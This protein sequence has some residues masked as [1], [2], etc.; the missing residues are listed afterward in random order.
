MALPGGTSLTCF[1]SAAVVLAC[2]TIL[3]AT[4]WSQQPSAPTQAETANATM[5]RS[6]FSVDAREEA[7]GAAED[8]GKAARLI[9]RMHSNPQLAK[10]PNEAKGIFVVPKFGRGAV[11]V[12]GEGGVGLL[13]LKHNNRW[14][15]PAFYDLGGV[16]VGAQIGGERPPRRGKLPLAKATSHCGPTSRGCLAVL[17]SA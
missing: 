17:R 16:S 5:A 2:S 15:D 4:A 11:G 12:D 9:Q 10:L 8:V 7:R 3:S 6:T 13:L 14:S 1:A